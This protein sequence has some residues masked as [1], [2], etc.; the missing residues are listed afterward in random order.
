[1]SLRPT[2]RFL[3]SQSTREPLP[4]D[5]H[6]GTPARGLTTHLLLSLEASMPSTTSLHLQRLPDVGRP[7]DSV[8]S[9]GLEQQ[10]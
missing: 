5:A 2:S 10:R 7:L 3:G 4:R 9:S 1:M 8:Y 6:A